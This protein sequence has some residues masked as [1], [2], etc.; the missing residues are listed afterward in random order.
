MIQ[1]SDAKWTYQWVT[2]TNSMVVRLPTSSTNTRGNKSNDNA[3]FAVTPHRRSAVLVKYFTGR[4][5]RKLGETRK[6]IRK[7]FLLNIQTASVIG[8]SYVVRAEER[9]NSALLYTTLECH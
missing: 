6:S 2:R 7:K 3:K 5:H 8:R 4:F 9:R 1:N